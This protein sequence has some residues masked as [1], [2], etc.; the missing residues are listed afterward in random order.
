GPNK[1][2]VTPPTAGLAI[3]HGVL[4]VMTPPRAATPH[5]PHVPVDYFFRS[6]AADQGARAIGIILSG[7]GTDGT[8]G[9]KAIKEAGGITFAQDPTTAKYDGMPRSAI[10]SGCV[11]AILAPRRSP[12]SSWRSDRTRTSSAR[13]RRPRSAASSTS[14][15]SSY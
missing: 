11:D 13:R 9:L 12:I 6:L 14:P 2:S 3:L 10:D 8:F 15:S 7:T 5:G 4:H 1:V